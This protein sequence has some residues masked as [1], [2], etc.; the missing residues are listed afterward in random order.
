M[1]TAGW[2]HIAVMLPEVIVIKAMAN[3]TTE[4]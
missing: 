3:N 2:E 1:L 4:V